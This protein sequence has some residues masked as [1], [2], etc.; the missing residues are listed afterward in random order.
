MTTIAE[1][2]ADLEKA[3]GPIASRIDIHFD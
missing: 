1:F 3:Y 2:I